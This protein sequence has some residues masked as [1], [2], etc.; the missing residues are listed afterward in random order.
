MG[1]MII[2]LWL[3]ISFINIVLAIA[4]EIKQLIILKKFDIKEI[5]QMMKKWKYQFKFVEESS[6]EQLHL[7]KLNMRNIIVDLI[8]SQ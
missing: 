3:S 5:I 8:I 1:E 4:I 2:N 7:I 6:W